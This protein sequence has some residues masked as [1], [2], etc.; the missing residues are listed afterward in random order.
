MKNTLKTFLGAI[1]IALGVFIFVLISNNEEKKVIENT[2]DRPMVS[3]TLA[4]PNPIAYILEVTGTLEAKNKVEIYSE[5]QGVMLPSRTPFKEGNRFLKGKELLRIDNREYMA[6]FQS[7]KSSLISQIA[8]ML[9]D[10]EIEF[11]EASKKWESYLKSFDMEVSL[12]ALP[13]TTSDKEKLFLMG[14][15][16]FQTYYNVKNQQERVSKYVIRAP[17]TGSVT[18]SNVNPGTLVRS[19]QKLGEFINTTAFELRLAIP[20]TANEYIKEGKPVALTTLNESQKLIGQISRI[21]DKI[22][23]ETQTVIAVVEVNHKDL[24][25]GQFLKA[26][27]EGMTIKDLVKIKGNLM[28]ENNHIYIVKDSVLTLQKI[29]PINYERDSVIVEGLES[30]MILLDEVLAMAYP[31]MKVNY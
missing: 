31:G 30:N 25:D 11:P 24:K 3:T 9:P 8:A 12:Q 26:K 27:I 1:V 22:N 2:P 29:V 28:L 15:G 21:N 18:E 10:M 17:F 6:Q 13:K 16:I 20:A 7:N 4:E 14:K 19:G 23:Q 5:V